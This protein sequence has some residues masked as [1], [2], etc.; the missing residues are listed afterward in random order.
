MKRLFSVVSGILLLC[1]GCSS[2]LVSMET[3][4]KEQPFAVETMRGE[5]AEAIL[6]VDQY[7]KKSDFPAGMWWKVNPESLPLLVS[8]IGVGTWGPPVSLVIDFKEMD[9]K[10]IASA[11]MHHGISSED[12]RRMI[13]VQ[14]L[15]AC[16][17]IGG[18]YYSGV[19]AI[20]LTTG[21]VL[22]GQIISIKDDELK[23]RSKEGRVFVFSFMKDIRKYIMK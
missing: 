11:Y 17:D 6:C 14:S 23:F 3:T 8:G 9:G 5:V 10:T 21:A 19:R 22:E 15:A 2:G 4:L 13:A 1:T 12:A 18:S 16:S 20:V 7:W